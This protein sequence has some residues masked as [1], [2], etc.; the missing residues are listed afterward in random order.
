[1]NGNRFTTNQQ[2]GT[3]V[4]SNGRLSEGHYA[5]KKRKS[6]MKAD[7]PLTT[8]MTETIFFTFCLCS[9]LLMNRPGEWMG[10]MAPLMSRFSSSVHL[11][12]T[13]NSFLMI[14]LSS[15]NKLLPLLD[16]FM[17]KSDPTFIPHKKVETA[18]FKLL[19][20]CF[21]CLWADW[22]GRNF[23]IQHLRTLLDSL[24][25]VPDSSFIDDDPRIIPIKISFQIFWTFDFNFT[26]Y[27][28]LEHERTL[29]ILKQQ[30]NTENWEV[31]ALVSRL[32][33]IHN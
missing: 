5:A 23:S 8:L 28:F 19:S 14:L 27:G 31:N 20:C 2:V 11:L 10:L 16:G 9:R 1:M 7:S 15:T 29:I 30:N 33:Q 13:I 18:I 32:Y 22:K 4:R 26:F 25:T 21:V 6:R 3:K 17:V 12:M 24:V